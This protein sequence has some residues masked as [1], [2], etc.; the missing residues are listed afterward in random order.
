MRAVEFRARVKDGLIVI[1]PEYRDLVHGHV[2]VIL[3]ADESPAVKVNMIDYLFAHPIEA[4]G[5]KP[6]TRE[7]AHSR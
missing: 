1:P 5:F 7:D 4:P 3:L 2:R 6:L